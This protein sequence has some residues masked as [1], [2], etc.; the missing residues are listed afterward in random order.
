MTQSDYQNMA[1][2]ARKIGVRMELRFNEALAQEKLT[3]PQALVVLYIL[4]QGEQGSSLTD[5]SERSGYSKGTL[6]AV[7]KRLRQMGYLRCEPCMED[8]R[9]R[10]RRATEQSRR[11]GPRARE[12]LGRAEAQFYR[13]ISR[14]DLQ[15]LERLQLQL[16]EN[17]S[18]TAPDA[19]KEGT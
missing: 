2:T 8:D 16:L 17:L 3:A 10:R 4:A 6:S 11:A 5:L 14:E 9:R 19:T 1:L 7:V 15:T 13:G 12:A 18:Q